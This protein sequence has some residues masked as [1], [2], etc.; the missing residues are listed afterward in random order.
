MLLLC[1]Q[2]HPFIIYC[3][4]S[5]HVH[6]NESIRWFSG[7]AMRMWEFHWARGHEPCR[8]YRIAWI[9]LGVEKVLRMPRCHPLFK[10]RVNQS[11]KA[12]NCHWTS[13]LQN[14]YM[15]QYSKYIF[16]GHVSDIKGK[17]PKWLKI[18]KDKERSY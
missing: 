5:L 10:G 12:L 4:Q 7:R 15:Y 13:Q 3:R 9:P 6:V 1:S 11:I 18:W 14:W 17:K 16:L 2:W 8:F